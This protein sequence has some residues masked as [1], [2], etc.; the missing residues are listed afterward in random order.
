MTDSLGLTTVGILNGNWA[1]GVQA[2]NLAN[3]EAN[4]FKG[5]TTKF[6][7]LVSDSAPIGV[8]TK[9][10]TTVSISGS[11]KNT[12]VSTNM[13]FE[14]ESMFVVKKGDTIGYTRNGSFRQ[15]AESILVNDNH[16]VLMGWRINSSS[17]QTDFTIDSLEE[18][19]FNNIGTIAVP[20]TDAVFDMNLDAIEENAKANGDD[21]NIKYS[22]NTGIAKNDIIV[23]DGKELVGGDQIKFSDN[24]GNET[25]LSYGGIA[26][27]VRILGSSLPVIGAK[28]TLGTFLD[29]TDGSIFTV[30]TEKSGNIIFQFSNTAPIASQNTFNSLSTLADAMNA[31]Q[32]LNA[33]IA[34]DGMLYVA[35]VD[36][37][38][39]LTFIGDESFKNSFLNLSTIFD[40]E[41]PQSQLISVNPV[42]TP[43]FGVSDMNT[44]FIG[45]DN[46]TSFFIRLNDGSDFTFTFKATSP[47]ETKGE[48]NSFT[49]LKDAINTTTNGKLNVTTSDTGMIINVNASE[50]NIDIVSVMK[51]SNATTDIPTNLGIV[52]NSIFDNSISDG[53][54]IRIN[55]GNYNSVNSS[56]GISNT[57]A[58]DNVTTVT[59]KKINEIDIFANA[60]DGDDIT[61]RIGEPSSE[62]IFTY[63][64]TSPATDP[65]TF[66]TISELL[67]LIQ[68]VTALTSSTYTNGV[69][70]VIGTGTSNISSITSTNG[71]LTSRM[72][73]NFIAPS[74]GDTLSIILTSGDQGTFTFVNNKDDVDTINGKFNT[75]QDL[76]NAI[77]E[78]IIG[79]NI[80]STYSTD[81]IMN[82]VPSDEMGSSILSFTGNIAKSVFFQDLVSGT[83]DFVFEKSNPDATQKQFND[84]FTLKKTIETISNN[85][86]QVSI[87]GNAKDGI[88]LSA[89]PSA[90]LKYICDVNDFGNSNIATQ[91][92]L[93]GTD[94]V[95]SLGLENTI[96]KTNRFATL[97]NLNTMIN[98][99]QFITSDFENNELVIY[100]GNISTSLEKNNI[101]TNRGTDFLS[102]FGLDVTQN[103]GYQPFDS[104]S[105][106]ASGQIKPNFTQTIRIYDSLGAAHDIKMSFLKIQNNQWNFEVYTPDK[107]EIVTSRDDGLLSYGT[108]EFSGDGFLANVEST[109]VISF[110]DN[111][112][113]NASLSF[114]IPVNAVWN[115]GSNHTEMLIHLGNDYTDY[116]ANQNA[117]YR[118]GSTLSQFAGEYSVRNTFQNGFGTSNLM[119]IDISEDGVISAI[120]SNGT[121]ISAYQI[122]AADFA[123]IEDLR[124]I[125]DN[126]YVAT[127]DSGTP[128]LGIPGQG[129]AGYVHI[130][131]VEG[132]NVEI[133]NEMLYMITT[134]NQ[135]NALLRLLSLTSQILEDLSKTVL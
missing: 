106:I 96:S 105:N 25:I 61:I 129:V 85:K 42:S 107:S 10:G 66:S 68:G 89:E 113:D 54:G 76:N 48:F 102:F 47:D 30:A 126:M 55:Y 1:L 46:G 29:A 128:D 58:L 74:D 127:S 24:L 37:T 93:A 75:M 45:I 72:N 112:N 52:I 114:N 2:E 122:A 33:R 8:L 9:T 32:F 38:D 119:N 94:F 82:I 88:T 22:Q 130:G 43:V 132:S 110:L 3:S 73:L 100:S 116:T 20:T 125:S 108:I 15:N 115:N 124:L 51:N 36:A 123:S 121:S 97:S 28:T 101:H 78:S 35:P 120:V 95:T 41:P 44:A 83:A 135:M 92:G 49:T 53:D 109:N 34:D 21:I 90:Q 16:S 91:M 65:N 134:K 19:N 11:F 80:K 57:V 86:V 64:S 131:F 99:N 81:E 13:A 59:S 17:E 84:L 79:N 103:S 27:S 69:L 77:N 23:P 50:T 4:A 18:I 70:K 63:T 56:V 62:N 26:R 14:S 6:L 98:E 5:N 118:S 7:T 71:D 67:T 111:K 87:L 31:S 39:S 133:P 104:N 117:G 12:G 60:K 40:Y